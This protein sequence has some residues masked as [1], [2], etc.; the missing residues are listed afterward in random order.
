MATKSL[1]TKIARILNDPSCG[2]FLLA[3]AKDADMAGGMAAPGKS[4]E[5]HA[6]EGRFRSLDDYREIIRQNV[7]QGLVDIML[8]SASTNEVLTLG[9]R[10]FD[11]SHVTPAIRANDTT[12]IWLAQGGQYTQQPARP[13]RTAEIDHGMCGKLDCSSEERSLGADLGLYSV[14]YNNDIHLDAA[15][16]EGYKAFRQEAEKKSF[17][18]FLEVFPPNAPQAPIGNLG[19]FINDNIARTLAGVAGKGRPLFLKVPYQGP[20]AMEQLVAYDRHLVVGI[21]GGSSGTT[22]DAFHQLWEAKKYGARVALY[23]RMINNSEHQSSFIRHLRLLADG[24]ITDPAEAVRSY[25]AA[26]AKRKIMPYRSLEDDLVSTLRQSAYGSKSSGTPVSKNTSTVKPTN[27]AGSSADKAA[28]QEET[29]DFSTMSQ[30]EKLQ[31]NRQRLDR[32]LG[33]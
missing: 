3:D 7:R 19:R 6:E 31:W 9:E 30:Q 29:P 18:H 28:T 32:T 33:T 22:F 17:R 4:P 10:I 20:A 27:G 8:M 15:M 2:D 14:T 23:G 1:D 11:S 25:H 13:F 12:D 26:L 21:L 5:H 16:L 24:E